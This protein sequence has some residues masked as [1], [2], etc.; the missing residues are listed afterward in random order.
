MAQLQQL[1]NLPPERN[2]EMPEPSWI[3]HLG[4]LRALLL[5]VEAP[6]F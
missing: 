1:P 6:E 5:L 4:C 2:A 3:P